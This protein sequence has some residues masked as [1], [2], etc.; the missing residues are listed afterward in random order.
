MQAI[1]KFCDFYQQLNVRDVSGLSNVYA[2]D[3]EFIDPIGKHNGI[4]ELTD[5]FN[6]L[7]SG[8][9]S[10]EFDI[11]SVDAIDEQ[12]YVVTWQMRFESTALKTP[13]PISVDGISIIKTNDS[14]VT[15]HRDY[16]DVGQMAYEHVPI[17]GYWV[18]KIKRRLQ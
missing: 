12:K 7:L 9:R 2:N 1:R 6:A 8:T 16:Y 14:H 10:C 17:L 18:R 13:T 15:Y 3:I 4:A 5:Y 11:D